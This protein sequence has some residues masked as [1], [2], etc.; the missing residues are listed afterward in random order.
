VNVLSGAPDGYRYVRKTDPAAA[1]YEVVDAEAQVV[2]MVFEM[3]TP[4][5][6]SINA[7]ARLLNERQVVTRTG[8]GRDCM[9]SDGYRRLSGPLGTNRPIRQDYLDKVVWARSSDF[10]MIRSSSRPK[11]I[12]AVRP[13]KK[14]TRCASANRNYAGSRPVWRKA[15]NAW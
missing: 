7:I 5:R 2:R 14:R 10:R 3:Y 4:Q 12:A 1:F 15:A 9:G 8:K 11:S 6:L 13:P